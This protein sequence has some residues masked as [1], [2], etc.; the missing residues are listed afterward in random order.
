[1]GEVRD[2]RAMVESGYDAVAD[3]YERLELEDRP[4]P[5]MRWLAALLEPVPDGARV[6]DVGCGN[7][8]PVTRAMAARFA[9]TGVD[10]SAA[11]LERAR[12]N[13]P[14]ATFVHGDLAT[15]DFD[16]PFAAIAALY[17][18]EHLP[19]ELHAD[20]FAR[21]HRWLEPGGRLMFTVEPYDEPG[22]VGDWL[23]HPMFFSQHDPE[24][25]LALVRDAGFEV[26]E[27]GVESQFEGD[28]DV[29]YLWV[30]AR[31]D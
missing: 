26:I 24:A 18:I 13:V 4:W 17:V 19:R 25:T 23:G 27:S 31:R 2:P 16:A 10:I 9:A 20:V 7:G 29:E 30:L 21:F 8:V 11:Q 28:H 12:R 15:V 3:A 5:R 1:M 22:V 14:G 6:L